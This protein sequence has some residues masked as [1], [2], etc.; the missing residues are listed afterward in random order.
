MG[1]IA[2]TKAL[3][4][5]FEADDSRSSSEKRK[6]DESAQARK[7]VDAAL[8]ALV[9]K[10]ELSSGSED[11]ASLESEEEQNEDNLDAIEEVSE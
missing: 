3:D 5:V 1:A 8:D 6:S 10:R 9:H 7:E 4:F 11:S 2:Q